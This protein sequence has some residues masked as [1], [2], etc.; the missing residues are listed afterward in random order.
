M[1]IEENKEVVREYYEEMLNKKDISLISKYLSGD[2]TTISPSGETL[3]G[4]EAL[5]K[6]FLQSWENIPDET[7]ELDEIIAEGNKVVV[8][9]YWTGTHSKEL[10][11][12][13]PT[14][15]SLR[16][17]FTGIYELENGKR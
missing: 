12:I 7:A 15:K 3:K 5:T 17:G 13:P 8:N 6:Y 9:G 14:G 4:I 10:R 1:G 16:Y 11:G 2:Y